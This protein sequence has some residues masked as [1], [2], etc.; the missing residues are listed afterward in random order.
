[1]S[2]GEARKAAKDVRLGLP[3]VVDGH[4]HI[5]SSKSAP[6]PLLYR[7]VREKAPFLKPKRLSR[8][9]VEDASGLSLGAVVKVS[10]G[11]PQS[12]GD[13]LAG[14]CRKAY[15]TTSARQLDWALQKQVCSP[16][17]VHPM[18][19]DFAHISGYPRGPE[20]LGV[21]VYRLRDVAVRGNE[22]SRLGPMVPHRST[23][24][25]PYY[26][27]RRHA[28][29]VEPNGEVFGLDGE[30]EEQTDSWVYNWYRKQYRDTLHAACRQPMQLLPM[31]H[32]D[33]RRWS[34]AADGSAGRTDPHWDNR[35]WDYPFAHIA[36]DTHVG[37]CLGFKMYTPLGYKPNDPRLPSLKEYYRR[38][39]ERQT[40]ILAHCSPGGMFTHDI[41]LY[42]QLDGADPSK[43]LTSQ[44][45]YLSYKT[46]E[47]TGYFW[48]NYV[49]PRAWKEVLDTPGLGALRLCLAHFGGDE[50]CEHG[51]ASHWVS[52][53]IDMTRR[54]D[55]VYTDVSC[56]DLSKTG[57]NDTRTF[58]EKLREF[59]YLLE[60][61]H[62]AHLKDRILFGTDWYMTHITR[63]HNCD[64]PHT[65][66]EMKR[67]LDSVSCRIGD[68]LWTRFTLIN[69]AT[70]YGLDDQDKLRNMA[71]ALTD[72]ASGEKDLTVPQ[73]RLEANL[74]R[75][76]AIKDM[77]EEARKVLP[78][79]KSSDAKAAA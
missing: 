49:H 6:L 14:A 41:D 17:V 5:N 53:I 37:P 36:R 61:S 11:S 54:Y 56:F 64:Y 44:T 20:E 35:R 48:H 10:S 40:P 22:G 74:E 3:C 8:A 63:S 46:Q 75:M 72:F 38:C 66:Y 7:Q 2:A 27:L 4:A 34:R 55:N 58:G 12:M 26:R 43:D 9:L 19:M 77:V 30:Y 71:Q 78:A 1:M 73:D 13:L 45:A 31:F 69:P 50:W 76:L 33:P 68:D 62:Y 21:P 18:D 67:L 65:V 23:R 57:P 59:L 79:V 47:A 60:E 32:Y 52:A 51:Y 39:A 70:F 15:E 42:A 24:K 16:I 25:Q 28:R 29:S